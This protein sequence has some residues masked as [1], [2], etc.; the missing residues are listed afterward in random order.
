ME[1][2]ILEEANLQLRQPCIKFEIKT[3]DFYH[4]S[5]LLIFPTKR[6]TSPQFVVPSIM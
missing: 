1:R 3:K 4:F 6:Q 2:K 5:F